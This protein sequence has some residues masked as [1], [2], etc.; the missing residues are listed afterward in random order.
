MRV[1][2]T[3]S[4]GFVGSAFK[5]RFE[6]IGG[7]DIVEVDLAHPTEPWDFRQWCRYED[8]LTTKFDMALHCAAVVGGRASIDGS[9]FAVASNLAL[10]HDFVR[11]A[12]QAKPKRTVLFS[13]SAVYPVAMQVADH[14]AMKLTESFVDLDNIRQ[15]DNSYGFAKLALEKLDAWAGLGATIFRPFSGYSHDQDSDYPFR[16]ILNRVLAKEDPVDVWS[17]AVRDFTHIEDITA[18]AMAF[19][20]DGHRGPV[21]L[22]TGRATSFTQLA[23]MMC[24]QVGHK[25]E[26]RVLKDM[27]TGVAHRVGDPRLMQKMHTPRISLEEGVAMAIRSAKVTAC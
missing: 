15:P 24:E 17:G 20:F 10:D 4:Q 2:I 23:A 9:P 13:S 3:G 22:C 18:A 8:A 12:V 21:N 14:P 6:Q 26:I 27:P 7:F 16:A 1:L 25:A 5:R 19:A 11:W